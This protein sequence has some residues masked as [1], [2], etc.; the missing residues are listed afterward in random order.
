LLLAVVVVVVVVVGGGGGVIVIAVVVGVVNL[1]TCLSASLLL[2]FFCP[3]VKMKIR[4]KKSKQKMKHMMLVLITLAVVL[5]LA[6]VGSSKRLNTYLPASEEIVWAAAAKATTNAAPVRNV[7]I[8]SATTSMNNVSSSKVVASIPSD[9]ADS[10]KAV[11]LEETANLP[12]IKPI[13]PPLLTIPVSSQQD[14]LWERVSQHDRLWELTKPF[15]NVTTY[16]YQQQ[17]FPAGY[18]NQMQSFMAFVVIGGLANHSQILMPTLSYKDT[19]GSNRYMPFE[20]LFDV[21][22]WNSF[23]PALPRL[24][25]CDQELFPNYHCEKR[26]WQE[27]DKPT[28][29]HVESRPNHVLFGNFRRYT[30]KHRGPMMA[31]GFPNPME[32]LMIKGALRPHPDLLVIVDRLLEDLGG[33][34]TLPY[35]TLHARV[36]PDMMKQRTCWNAKV[37]N[38]TDIFRFLEET[39]PDPPATRIFMPINRNY[40]E[41]GGIINTAHPNETN[42]MAVHNLKELNRAV[43]DG[44][45]GGRAKIF[46]FGS[47]ALTGTKYESR[48][49]TS[50]AI[51]NFFMAQN[52]NVFVGTSVSTYSMDLLHARFYNANIENYQYLPSGLERWT[53]KT[54]KHPPGF[55]C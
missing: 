2:F 10:I 43:E 41:Y 35:M 12:E 45:W 54:T 15:A 19:F 42:W 25:H 55:N 9:K 14:G 13:K 11:I 24:V 46:E 8:P 29:L 18:R 37:T 20:V 36:E 49:A 16:G 28:L 53:D 30:V 27:T 40:M 4:V 32:L 26:R 44:L 48:P 5:L 21:E 39:F 3:N 7:I 47:N 17:T 34:G 23:Y 1:S 22:H 51:L 50:G 33:N 52:S 6:S 38:L 31:G